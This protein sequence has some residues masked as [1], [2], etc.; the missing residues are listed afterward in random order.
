MGN[1]SSGETS[2]MLGRACRRS[3]KFESPSGG[4]SA[5]QFQFASGVTSREERLAQYQALK[6]ELMRAY[7][8]PTHNIRPDEIFRGKDK[9]VQGLA[10]E[11]CLEW[12]GRE[13]MISLR[14]SDL[15]LTL[16]F[17]QAPSSR[18]LAMRQEAAKGRDLLNKAKG[19]GN[20]MP[21]TPSGST[22]LK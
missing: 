17:R 21:L 6:A 14:L 4:L 22:P 2:T 16:Q 3:L 10:G 12:R 13:T 9:Y 18:A 7:Q 1:G 19:S 20:A 15:E 11:Y 5:V 8:A